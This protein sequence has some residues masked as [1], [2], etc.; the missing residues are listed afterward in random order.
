MHYLM[1]IIDI[2]IEN[3]WECNFCD[4]TGYQNF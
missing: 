2:L 3:E 1:I 4:E